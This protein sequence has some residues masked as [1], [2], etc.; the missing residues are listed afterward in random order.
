MTQ[1]RRRVRMCYITT[2][3]LWVVLCCCS[4]EATASASP[5]LESSTGSSGA[6]ESNDAS[7]PLWRRDLPANARTSVMELLFPLYV[8]FLYLP[9]ASP[10]ALLPPLPSSNPAQ[11]QPPLTPPLPS[12]PRSPPSLSPLPPSSP[13]SQPPIMPPPSP[14]PPSPPPRAASLGFTVDDISGAAFP[15]R[16]SSRCSRSEAS[17]Y[18]SETSTPSARVRTSPTSPGRVRAHQAA[19]E[20]VGLR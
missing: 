2:S 15:A 10:P 9:P 13:P 11:D 20:A 6:A 12:S 18:R 14:L 8:S 17:P 1:W 3:A 16:C 7:W 4:L 19:L 5:P